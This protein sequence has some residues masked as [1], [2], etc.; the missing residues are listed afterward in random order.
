MDFIAKLGEPN[1]PLAEHQAKANEQHYEVPTSFLKLCLGPRMKYSSCYY[2]SLEDSTRPGGAKDIKYAKESLAEAEEV[3]LKSYCEKAGLGEQGP[4]Q[5]EG[6]SI[7]D[8]GCGWGSL[9][10]YLAEKYPKA[11]IKMLSNSRTQKVHIDGTC[12]EKGFGNVEVSYKRE[13]MAPSPAI[14]NAHRCL[15]G[16]HWR[17]HAI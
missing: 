9:G 5:G 8:L 12:K 17:L 3:M 15:P 6:L 1:R 10:L 16:D 11:S 13:A 2:P 4:G 7:L 14:D